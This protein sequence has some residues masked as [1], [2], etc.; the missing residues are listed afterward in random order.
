MSFLRHV[1]KHGDR[2]VAVIFREVPGEPH[3]C[4]VAYT[5]ILNQHIHDPLIK[6]IESDIGQNSE[7]LADALNRTHTKDG[8]IILQKLHAEGMLK[9]VNTEQIV[10]TP[11][12]NTKIKLNEL[13]KILDEMKQGE[14]AT[15]RLAEMDKSLGMQDAAQVA[16]RMRGDKLPQQIN[17]N[18]Q[19]APVTSS[20]ASDAL[21]DT[22]LANNLRQQAEKM[23]RE[24]N[25]LM[26]EA[27]RLLKEAASLDPVKPEK[28]NK[29]P[30]T[31]TKVRKTR[32][33]VTA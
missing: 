2:K 10:M 18:R 15:K 12:P 32:A 3:M 11:A 9:K 14:E 30:A 7:N 20:S 19:Q 22:Q 4:L 28:V 24:A 27:Q 16:R 17:E 5:E 25:G 8:H 33:K 6:C 31:E 29:T 26:L 1:G 13:N 23:S 21:G